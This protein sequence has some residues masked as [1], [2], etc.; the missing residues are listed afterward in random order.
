MLHYSQDYG[1]AK[2]RGLDGKVI[3]A[4]GNGED[5]ADQY[6]LDENDEAMDEEG[7]TFLPSAKSSSGG[8]NNNNNKNAARDFHKELVHSPIEKL[9]RDLD[10]SLHKVQLMKASFYV[11]DNVPL[12]SCA[13]SSPL[14]FSLS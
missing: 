10:T 14:F 9:A 2:K 8:S 6:I 4:G 3:T 1:I 11:D 13:A 7:F 5:L 12:G